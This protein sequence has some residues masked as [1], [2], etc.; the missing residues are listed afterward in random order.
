MSDIKLCKNGIK[1]NC[2]LLLECRRFIEEPS[3]DQE[4]LNGDFY[5]GECNFQ[6]KVETLQDKIEQL[7]ND[8]KEFYQDYKT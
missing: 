6:S 1:L 4:Y 8:R 3:K 5:A 2:T 7:N